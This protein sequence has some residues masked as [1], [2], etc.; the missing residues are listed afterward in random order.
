MVY[1]Q[2]TQEELCCMT[3]SDQAQAMQTFQRL[4]KVTEEVYGHC[5][6]MA[7]QVPPQRHG[8]VCAAHKMVR[9]LWVPSHIESTPGG[10]LSQRSASASW[11]GCRGK[12]LLNFGAA[13]AAG[14]MNCMGV[15][16]MLEKGVVKG[17]LVAG[18]LPY[19]ML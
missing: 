15:H 17:V 18:L 19:S 14:V 2:G 4:R 12:K 6:S 3:R 13:S 11:P 16:L 10:P 8:R 7:V 1:R 9:E 5:A